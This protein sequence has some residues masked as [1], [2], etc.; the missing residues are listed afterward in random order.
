MELNMRCCGVSP[1]ILRNWS[2][3]DGFFLAD[4]LPKTDV[5]GNGDEVAPRDE[6]DMMAFLQT[7]RGR[8][9]GYFQQAACH[10][11]RMQ[12]P[13]FYNDMSVAVPRF[14][15]ATHA[16]RTNLPGKLCFLIGNES[17]P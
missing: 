15:N 13:L 5:A 1:A 9:A 16:L 11:L 14:R 8:N 7:F 4:A 17:K 10:G 12:K 2:S 3:V 6:I